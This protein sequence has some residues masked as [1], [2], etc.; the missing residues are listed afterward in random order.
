[1]PVREM[2]PNITLPVSGASRPIMQFRKVDL[3]APFG[4]MI[5]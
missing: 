5:A 2:S 4:P 1:M 3:P